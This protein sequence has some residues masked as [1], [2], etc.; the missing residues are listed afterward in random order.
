MTPSDSRH[1]ET[2]RWFIAHCE[3]QLRLQHAGWITLSQET[4]ATLAAGHAKA[5]ELLAELEDRA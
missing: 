5:R 4:V 3:R 2:L 1:A